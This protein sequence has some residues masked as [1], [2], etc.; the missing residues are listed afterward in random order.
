MEA[1]DSNKGLKLRHID[2]SQ[3]KI[4]DKGGYN[5]ANAIKNAETLE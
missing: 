1:F 2:L 4:N 3:N 5:I